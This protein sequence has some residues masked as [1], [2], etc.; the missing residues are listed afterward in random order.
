MA[1]PYGRQ[2]VLSGLAEVA[3]AGQEGCLS[4]GPVHTLGTDRRMQRCQRGLVV[5][6]PGSD[7]LP[8]EIVEGARIGG[9]TN[10]LAPDLRKLPALRAGMTSEP[11]RHASLSSAQT[12]G[13]QMMRTAPAKLDQQVDVLRLERGDL[14]QAFDIASH[15]ARLLAFQQLAQAVE[16]LAF[17]VQARDKIGM[18]G[19]RFTSCA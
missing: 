8:V 11:I 14:E 16:G 13:F 17:R 6:I 2:G 12:H 5:R 4:V 15:Q 9:K 3:L 1:V 10:E 7:Q 19:H 18:I